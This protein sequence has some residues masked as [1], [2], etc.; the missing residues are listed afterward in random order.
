MQNSSLLKILQTFSK[1]ELLAL[2][3]FLK[4]GYFNPN[5]NCE[6]LFHILCQYHPDFD[7]PK[8]KAEKL[9]YRIF[10][11]EKSY[12]N[13][14]ANFRTLFSHL[15]KCVNQFLILEELEKNPAQQ[16]LLLLDAYSRKDVDRSLITATIK[17]FKVVETDIS[18]WY[19]LN[20]FLLYWKLYQEDT[21]DFFNRKTHY[22]D[23]LNKNFDYFYALTKLKLGI[24][25]TNLVKRGVEVSP[26][27]LLPAIQ[28][29]IQ[30]QTA[31]PEVLI[32]YAKLYKLMNKE[33]QKIN[34]FRTVFDLFQSTIDSLAI[35]EAKEIAAILFN[36]S[37]ANIR[38]HAAAEIYKKVRFEILKLGV[39]RGLYLEDEII[40]SGMF[41]AIAIG[42]GTVAEFKWAFDF[43]DNYSQF[44]PPVS[45]DMNLNTSK[46][47]LYFLKG[48]HHN[49][50]VDYERCIHFFETTKTR[51]ILY[52]QRK[53]W[54]LLQAH[55]EHFVL[56]RNITIFRYTD[57]F[58]VLISR[59]RAFTDLEKR[60][61]LNTNNAIK[62]LA[63]FR[64][65]PDLKLTIA[66]AKITRFQA[67]EYYR[68]EWVMA[69]I[70][71]F[72]IFKF[73]NTPL[74]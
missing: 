32:L 48:Q 59:S 14:A 62:F 24:E 31:L 1:T 29:F 65:H 54:L 34:S 2:K 49:S 20:H 69:K 70:R 45:K 36:I 25:Q 27:E 10:A 57:N 72:W 15:K 4:T 53:I 50:A 23:L 47:V 33:A 60:T 22:F 74:D 9:F 7:S 63:K 66:K 11:K 38:N 64:H 35:E 52:N 6:K 18:T 56:T 19:Y 44:L 68:P 28:S 40:S 42:A 71:E 30:Q 12:Q 13:N 37:N 3:K 16:N 26:L 61:L 51:N 8:L 58:H 17:K 5:Q 39:E 55:Y 67:L 73:P 43:I 46:G 41:M 21:K